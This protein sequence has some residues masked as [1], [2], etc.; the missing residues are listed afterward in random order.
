MN[1]QGSPNPNVLSFQ[2]AIYENSPD[3]GVEE[4][5]AKY[6]FDLIQN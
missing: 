1:S 2:K 6:S 3:K 4:D 5:K